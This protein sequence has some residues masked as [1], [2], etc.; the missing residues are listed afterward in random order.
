MRWLVLGR[1]VLKTKL[2]CQP[3]GQRPPALPARCTSAPHSGLSIFCLSR[4]AAW[5]KLLG[6]RGAWRPRASAPSPCTPG[7]GCTAHWQPAACRCM[8]QHCAGVCSPM[9]GPQRCLRSAAA[10]RR[11]QSYKSASRQKGR[12]WAWRPARGQFVCF[13][14]P[15]GRRQLCWSAGNAH[16][17]TEARHELLPTII[18]ICMRMHMPY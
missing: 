7:R 16:E 3:A 12:A 18:G 14:S 5:A 9:H 11:S 8:C 13:S 4:T 2:A 17:K 15:P 10:P 6:G 1:G